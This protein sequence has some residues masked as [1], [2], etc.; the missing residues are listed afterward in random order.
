MHIPMK[1]TQPDKLDKINNLNMSVSPANWEILKAIPPWLSSL[2]HR[3][4]WGEKLWRIQSYR[5]MLGFE[6]LVFLKPSAGAL[7]IF[8]ETNIFVWYN[9]NELLE[10]CSHIWMSQKCEIAIKVPKRYESHSF[11]NQL[12]CLNTCHGV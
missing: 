8:S 3:K 5:S 2:S 11:R 12:W 6:T 1:N 7:L 4:G 9:K 10:K